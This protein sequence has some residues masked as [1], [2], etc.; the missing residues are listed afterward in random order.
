MQFLY[1]QK[2]FTKITKK[3]YRLCKIAKIKQI[4]EIFD[5]DQKRHFLVVLTQQ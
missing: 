4:Y 1:F 5:T 2:L 3:H